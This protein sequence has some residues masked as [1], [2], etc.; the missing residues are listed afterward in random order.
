MHAIKVLFVLI[1][2]GAL[3]ATGLFYFVPSTRPRFV[4]DWFRKASGFTPAKT[5][6]EAIDKFKKALQDRDYETAA[7]YCDP[8]YAEQLRKGAE[9]AQKLTRAIDSLRNSMEKHG[10]KSDKVKA[11]LYL[12]EPFPLNVKT[13]DLKEKD[14]SAAAQLVEEG[15]SSTADTGKILVKHARL[16]HAFL[17]VVP[18]NGK[19]ELFRE[20]SGDKAAW[21]LKIPVT[22]RLRDS[23]DT[24]KDSGTNYANAIQQVSDQV[25]NN[26]GTK[27]E[28]ER[29]LERALDESK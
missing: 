12:L 16:V 24:L 6:T 9:G 21:K 2:V 22:P 5:P 4:Q 8:D 26:P 1:V 19:V 13:H 15:T 3:G 14:D 11:A 17:P 20:G 28:V 25:K 29:E 27:A 18:W 10:V 7:T 23:V